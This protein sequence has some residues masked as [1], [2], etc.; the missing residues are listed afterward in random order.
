VFALPLQVLI[1]RGIMPGRLVLVENMFKHILLA[2]A[3]VIA[4]A[5]SA[6]AQSIPPNTSPS[7]TQAMRPMP[8]AGDPTVTRPAPAAS[9]TAQGRKEAAHTMGSQ[10]EQRITDLRR[11]LQIT[12]AQEP[13]W[14]TF[15]G[16]MRDHARSMDTTFQRRV[17]G[18]PEMNAVQNMQSYAQV[19]AAHAADMQ[20]L[21]APFESLYSTLSERQRA[22]ADKVFRD[23]A[24]RDTGKRS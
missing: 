23:D 5:T 8:G 1:A 24:R 2:G 10:I 19:S 20:R 3:A 21:V 16:V 17:Q 11:K 15:T 18:M 4:L 14:T 9:T 22:T 7:P 13:Q 6:I 12:P